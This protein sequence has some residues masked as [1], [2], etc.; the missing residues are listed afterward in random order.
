MCW[1]TSLL[2]GRHSTWLAC[3]PSEPCPSSLQPVRRCATIVAPCHGYLTLYEIFEV[4]T[5]GGTDMS[6]MHAERQRH[7]GG[8]VSAG[9]PVH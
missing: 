2:Q 5:A 9:D 6:C 8:R 7:D 4:H 3:T 1:G